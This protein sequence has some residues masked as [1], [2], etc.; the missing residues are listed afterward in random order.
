MR[1]VVGR[2]IA[3]LVIAM[4]PGLAL[5][6]AYPER[7]VR[8]VVAYPPGGGVDIVA[9]ILSAPLQAALK[10]PIIIDN[11]SGAGGA[12]GHALVA[13]AT[14][15]G[16]TLLLAAAGPLV[17]TKMM[18]TVPYDPARDFTPIAMVAN[19]GVV[20]VASNAFKPRTVAEI[21]DYAKANPGKVNLAINSVGSLY[22]ILSEL[23]M[24][25]TGT[26]MNRVP[27]K[28][29]AP[30][31]LDLMAGAVDIEIESVPVAVQNIR[32]QRI[33]AL[34]VASKKRSELM[35]N[36][37]TFAELGMPEMVAAPWYALVGP[38][39]VPRAVVSRL[40][41]EFNDILAQPAIGAQF[42]KQGIDPVIASV[43][44][45][46]SFVRSEIKRWDDV[47]VKT[48]IKLGQG[49]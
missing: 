14:P 46:E 48:G 42:S 36:V 28:G 13:K 40:N 15:D 34:A 37:P 44:D 20:L 11:R 33:R 17:G 1:N 8:I 6:K 21:I 9:R 10:Q 31:M 12:V 5:A 38:A 23:M 4:L 39:G 49:E 47:V 18:T 19:L 43:A 2:G 3:A 30:A 25:S 35:P 32:A 22:H 7:P 24:L 45:T 26:T 16:H 27:Y 29:A 41:R